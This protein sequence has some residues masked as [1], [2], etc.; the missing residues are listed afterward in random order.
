MNYYLETTEKPKTPPRSPHDPL[1]PDQD[2]DSIPLP[3]DSP[4][5]GTP[6]REPDLPQP[7]IDPQPPEPTRLLLN[8]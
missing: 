3:P 7:I 6:V 4:E 1:D 8:S 5:P 2:P